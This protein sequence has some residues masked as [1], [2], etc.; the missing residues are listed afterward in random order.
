M[1]VWGVPVG[2]VVKNSL[3]N[4]WDTGSIPGSGRSP[5]EGNS[6]PL[7]ERGDIYILKADSHCCMVETNTIL[8]SNYT[9]IK[10]KFEKTSLKKK[11][12]LR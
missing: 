9:P 3:A 8:Y 4:A 6:N 1:S 5:G 7:Q 10:N 2:S 11:Y 12:H